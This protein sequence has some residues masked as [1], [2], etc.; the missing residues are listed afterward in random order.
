MYLV[1]LFV[2][3]ALVLALLVFAAVGDARAETRAL[4]NLLADRGL[5]LSTKAPET[6]LS[7][8]GVI[9]GVAV[10]VE[11]RSRDQLLVRASRSLA[12]VSASLSAPDRPAGYRSGAMP[13][14][15]EPTLSPEAVETA[16]RQ[17]LA[18]LTDKPIEISRQ[19]ELVEL[20][21]LSTELTRELVD[22]AVDAALALVD[23]APLG[24]ARDF[25]GPN[26]GFERMIAFGIAALG[27]FIAAL[28]VPSFSPAVL[29]VLSPWSCQ[30]GDE[31]FV[32]AEQASSGTGYTN[33]CR[34]ADGSLHCYG[35][36]TSFASGFDVA[37]PL[38][39]LGAFAV[40]VARRNTRGKAAKRGLI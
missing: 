16:A 33:Y 5:G 40:I 23:G 10:L 34:S 11:R 9:D 39:Y 21:V 7:V 20:R 27:G 2:L 3:P 19:A 30:P 12:L 37:F 38:I 24:R 36:A 35:T 26:V 31:L 25:R 13:G 15:P 1:G 29:E 14:A 17:A 22:R 6:L 4:R 32:L 18:E 28:V 8:A